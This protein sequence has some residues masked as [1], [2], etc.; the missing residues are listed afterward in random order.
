MTDIPFWRRLSTRLTLLILIIVLVLAI[1]TAILVF[2]GFN[3]ISADLSQGLTVGQDP[4]A[5]FS[6]V[7][8]GT[9]VNLLAI[10][11]LT[12]IG[13]AVFSRTLLTEPIVTL[14]KGT[15]EIA[16]GKLGIQLPVTSNTELGMLAKAF[17]Q[18]AVSLDSR[19]QELLKANEA[20]RE[21]EARLEQRVEERTSEL[22]AL[23]ELSNS[24]ALTLDSSRLLDTIL[25]KLK[26]V[27]SYKS[28]CVFELADAGLNVLAERDTL[29]IK[30]GK[31]RRDV[32]TSKQTRVY[33]GDSCV[34][35][36]VPLIVR[37][38]CI[39]VMALEHPDPDY[40]SE[41]RIRLALAFANQVA[42]AL[43]NARL[44]EQV[45][46]KAAHDERQHLARELHDSVSQ[47]L[48]SI[49]LGVHAARKQLERNPAKAQEPLEYVQNLA[50]AGLAEMRALIFE[51]RPDVLEQEGLASAMRKQTEALEVRHQLKT[52][53]ED[54]GEPD[55]S[56]PAKQALYRVA[57]EALHNV[58][59]H[60]KASHT[61]VSLHQNAKLVHL[62]IHDDG[63]GFEIIEDFPG[64]L[65]LKSMRERIDALGGRFEVSSAL[66]QG[67]HIH[68]EV[69]IHA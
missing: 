59:K 61:S 10:F 38:T 58:V 7:A 44:Y 5:Q 43:E 45:Q 63:A 1:A 68:V 19:T 3:L 26:E 30:A 32:I 2:R 8:E 64:H 29:H 37:E 51:L 34:Q 13:A 53:F 41:D 67:T 69:P 4:D 46:Q 57:Q 27:V 16:E 20:L 9:I 49:V 6:D 55:L 36:N 65:G 60:A 52:S 47:A 62:D 25:D 15:Q 31:Q 23:L 21:S 42:V 33:S 35:L 40:F 22:V 24:T 54:D 11:L 17:N 14:V 66:G 28:L 39:G 48:Y 18:M 50:E 56:F 12:L